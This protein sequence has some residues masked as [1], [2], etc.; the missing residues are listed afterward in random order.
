MSEHSRRERYK[1][2]YPWK[3]KERGELEKGTIFM[4]KE[5]ITYLKR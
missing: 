5:S 4:A 1:T 3:G 2:D